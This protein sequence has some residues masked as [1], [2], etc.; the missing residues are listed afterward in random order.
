MALDGGMRAQQARRGRVDVGLAIALNNQMTCPTCK[1]VSA[2]RNAIEFVAD[3]AGMEIRHCRC[4]A[5]AR[6]WRQIVPK[7][8]SA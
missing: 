7:W 1:Y 3:R 4:A 5:C 8:G 2:A 6:P